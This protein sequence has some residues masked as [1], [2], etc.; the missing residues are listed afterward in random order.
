MP[1]IVSLAR[2]RKPGSVTLP[3]PAKASPRDKQLNRYLWS[4]LAVTNLVDLLASRR[5][6][7]LGIGELNPI[8]D[9]LFS[10]YGISSVAVFKLFWLTALLVL[11][12]YVR[13]WTQAFF[14]FACVIYLGLTLL[15]IARLS[16]LL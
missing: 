2:S 16:P 1:I 9:W 7:D 11:L 5:A 12:P 10:A 15:H 8:V 13:G 3:H 14:A 6:F 4:L